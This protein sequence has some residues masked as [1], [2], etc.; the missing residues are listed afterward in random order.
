MLDM[1]KMENAILL[2]LLLL[3]AIVLDMIIRNGELIDM[4]YL[5]FLIGCLF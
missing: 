3:I 4:Y 5:A 2:C 1:K